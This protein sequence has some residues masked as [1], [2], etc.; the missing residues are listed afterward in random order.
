[1]TTLGAQAAAWLDAHCEA[2]AVAVVAHRNGDL[3]TVGSS[4]AL[5]RAWAPRARACGLHAVRPAAGLLRR[6]DEHLMIMDAAAVRLPRDLAGLV[7]VDTATPDQVG[8]RLPEDVPTMVIDH[9]ATG[10]GWDLDPDGLEWRGT[11]ASTAEMIARLLLDHAPA[12]LDDTVRQLLLAG[13]LA[14]TGRFRHAGG[15]SLRVAADLLEEAQFDWSSF[16]EALEGEPLDHSQRVALARGLSRVEPQQA[17]PWYVLVS[18]AGSQEGRLAS[19]LLGAGADVSVVSKRLPEGGTRV[20]VRASAVAR[21][22]GLDM[23]R[24]LEGLAT[25]LG[26]EGGGHPGAA[27]WTGPVGDVEARSAVIAALSGTVRRMA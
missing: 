23:G 14:D 1:M 13:I 6:L 9:H 21:A 7:I 24:L 26:G 4:V 2:G 19:L 27:G 11:E 12:R 25:R 22:G 10:G 20:T 16:V 17:G 5:A 8:F 3:D 18:R 15:S